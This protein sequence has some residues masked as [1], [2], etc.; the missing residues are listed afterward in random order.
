[1]PLLTDIT[2]RAPDP[3]FGEPFVAEA[4]PKNGGPAMNAHAFPEWRGWSNLQESNEL[5]KQSC[6]CKTNK[7]V[8]PFY[9][10]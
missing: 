10:N 5:V 6:L 1:M 4:A 8:S 9:A 2:V 3:L 7:R